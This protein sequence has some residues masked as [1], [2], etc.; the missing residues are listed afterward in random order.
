MQSRRAEDYGTRPPTAARSRDPRIEEPPSD[1]YEM[2][3][4][5]VR[6][7]P[8]GRSLSPLRKSLDGGGERRNGSFEE[9]DLHRWAVRGRI[10]DPRS[11]SACYGRSDE[12]PPNYDDNLGKYDFV[13]RIVDHG[14]AWDAG[15][16]RSDYSSFRGTPDED[17]VS[18]VAEHQLMDDRRTMMELVAMHRREYRQAELESSI[19]DAGDSGRF[20]SSSRNAVDGRFSS[21]Q[22]QYP[23]PFLLEGV[24]A[25]EREERFR[26]EKLAALESRRRYGKVEELIPKP[27]DDS[28]LK[29]SQSVSKEFRHIPQSEEYGGTHG[30]L[31]SSGMNISGSYQDDVPSPVDFHP[32]RSAQHWEPYRFYERQRIGSIDFAEKNEDALGYRRTEFRSPTREGRKREYMYPRPCRENCNHGHTSVDL[33][34]RLHYHDKGGYYYRD[35]SDPGYSRDDRS[36]P[37]GEQARMCFDHENAMME[38]GEV[39]L[40]PEV[41]AFDMPARTHSSRERITNVSERDACLVCGKESTRSPLDTRYEREMQEYNLRR[42]GISSDIHYTSNSPQRPLKRKKS[43]VDEEPTYYRTDSNPNAR[44]K[45]INGKD[46]LEI[47]G[48]WNFE[49]PSDFLSSKSLNYG[50]SMN[51]R[52]GRGVDHNE[53][54]PSYKLSL[55]GDQSEYLQGYSSKQSKSEKRTSKGLPGYDSYKRSSS[56]HP[57]RNVWVRDEDNKQLEGSRT[58]TWESKV[59][60]GSSES[61]LAEDSED[62]KERVQKSF[63]SFSKIMNE[64]KSTRRRYKEQG[65]AGTLYCIVCGKSSSKD[66][67]DTR[68]LANH[69]YMSRKSGLRA[70]HLGLHKA[71][72]VLLGWNSVVDH[73]VTTF[74]PQVISSSEALAQ[75][76]DLILW[77]P[78]IIIHSVSMSAHRSGEQRFLTKEGVEDFLRGRGITIGKVKVSSGISAN[79]D[80]M[81]VK[82]LGTFPG[83]Q[84]AKNLHNYFLDEKCGRTDL[85]QMTL[86]KSERVLGDKLEEPL[87]YGYMGIS[88]DLDKVDFDT[89]RRCSIRSK[90]EIEYIAEAPLM[91]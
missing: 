10:D 76:E 7:L 27:W 58:R 1:Y 61:G 21:E 40:K 83:L 43:L 17:R 75:K 54:S 77:P 85:E 22:N 11:Q 62:F 65:R 16:K 87:L 39:F 82:F 53:V 19:I 52:T 56:N 66:F 57:S 35:Q 34:E 60:A 15:F 51:R 89:K 49:E 24:A 69:C 28:Y 59:T 68:N 45:N 37:T 48:K 14:N 2:P 78:T 50:H 31:R 88:E 18:K 23:D 86:S 36:L 74:I 38:F 81:V 5:D 47:D 26:E 20:S 63:L 44:M 46:Q 90:W 12:R 13:D 71:I 6:S 64:K 29:G 30:H 67:V 42:K 80:I 70:Q 84:E 33:P 4:L 3:H 79:N 25:L 73:D 9:R 55:S 72:C 41:P 8:P 32:N 91:Q